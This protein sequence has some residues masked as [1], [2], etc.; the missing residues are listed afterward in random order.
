MNKTDSH[1][2]QP[3]YL[4]PTSRLLGSCCT[5]PYVIYICSMRYLHGLSNTI[6]ELIDYLTASSGLEKFFGP[7]RPVGQVV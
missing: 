4:E 1:L 6:S 2:C 7:T 3:I 5:W